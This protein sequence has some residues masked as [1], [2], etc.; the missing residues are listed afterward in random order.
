MSNEIEIRNRQYH[1]RT[2]KQCFLGVDAVNWLFY[3]TNVTSREDA[4]RLGRAMVELYVCKLL[5]CLLHVITD[6][7]AIGA[8]LGN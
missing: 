4:L 8:A 2:Y 3:N 7:L 1:F 5:V 6:A